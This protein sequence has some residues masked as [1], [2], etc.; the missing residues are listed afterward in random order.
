MPPLSSQPTVSFS[1]EDVSH[2]TDVP[3]VMDRLRSLQQSNANLRAT[4][5]GLRAMVERLED[6][7]AAETAASQRLALRLTTAEQRERE[8]IA[9]LLHDHLQQLLHGAK[10]WAET[11]QAEGDNAPPESLDRIVGLLVDAMDATRSLTADLSPAGLRTRGLGAA[12]EDLADQGSTTLGLAIAL[13][14]DP[15]VDRAPRGD[16]EA[17][18]LQ[19]LFETT[20]ELL[21]NVA[22]HA[23]VDAATVRARRTPDAFVVEVV[24]AGAGF[25]PSMLK[26]AADD[27]GGF[28]LCRI[29]ERLTLLGGTLDVTSAPGAGTRVRVS[30]PHRT[31][32]GARGLDV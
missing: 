12:L 21:F 22:K 18:R 10:M 24:D 31:P 23:G 5:D 1:A 9:S 17:T 6:R 13:D 32:P 8:R 26:A 27:D 11:L 7:L 14:V 20:R 4:H 16:A 3:H 25:D 29:R 19:F 28:G 15:G 30:V 2:T